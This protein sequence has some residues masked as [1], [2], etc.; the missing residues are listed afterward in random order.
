V[1]AIFDSSLGTCDF[2]LINRKTVALRE[3]CCVGWPSKA[4]TVA[5]A[6]EGLS[7]GVIDVVLAHDVPELARATLKMLVDIKNATLE[8]MFSQPGGL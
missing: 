1:P 4:C 3:K 8:R 5:T 7:S 2:P 6:K